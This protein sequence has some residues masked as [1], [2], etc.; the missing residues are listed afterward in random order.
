MHEHDNLIKIILGVR[1]RSNHNILVIDDSPNIR[2]LIKRMLD[3]EYYG[4]WEANSAQS[5]L[6]RFDS[7][8]PDV[9]LLDLG[10]PDCEGTQLIPQIRERTSA[11]I[12]VVSA[13]NSIDDMV[14]ALDNGADDYVLK[15]FDVG[16]LLA[17]IRAAIRHR[18]S[19]RGA[20]WK[21]ISGDVEIDL[22]ARRI[23][24]RNDDVRLTPKEYDVVAELAKYQGRIIPH[25]HLLK[26]VWKNEYERH[27]EYLRVV[28]KNIRKKIEDDAN[29][30]CVIVN[31]RGVGYRM[32]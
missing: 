19:A 16:E 9:I 10:L 25:D 12:I 29:N 7:V 31:E 18:I 15:P 8:D 23:R 11:P 4:F 30:P 2:L 14:N 22:V 1:M 6:E 13:R 28:I 32:A 21:I 5:A 17:R 26:V 27:V 3:E 24:K 20:Q